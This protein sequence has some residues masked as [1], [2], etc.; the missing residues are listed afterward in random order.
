[1]I[2][3]ARGTSHQNQP[4]PKDSSER[5]A[6]MN[7]HKGRTTILTASPH[8]RRVH[9]RLRISWSR[10]IPSYL[11]HQRIQD[12]VII[13]SEMEHDKI[14]HAMRLFERLDN[15]VDEIFA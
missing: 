15:T 3:D 13:H 1:M 12:R 4:S 10:G 11:S 2:M 7:H 8:V 6:Q 14:L 5:D 9:T